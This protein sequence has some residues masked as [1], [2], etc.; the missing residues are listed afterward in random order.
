MSE[1]KGLY[2]KAG[3]WDVE[4]RVFPDP[5]WISLGE[6]VGGYFEIVRCHGFAPS[7]MLLL[8]DD[9][10]VLKDKPINHRATI[11]AGQAIF[12]DA[13]L[14]REGMV[15]GEPDCVSLLDRDFLTYGL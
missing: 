13:V 12:G 7:F 1:L 5:T 6:A 9:E 10:G 14:L 11:L 15:E 8:V 4:E 2:F 3:S